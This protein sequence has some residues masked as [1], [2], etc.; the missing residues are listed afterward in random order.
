MID[1][2]RLERGDFLFRQPDQPIDGRADHG[3]FPRRNIVRHSKI[4][5]RAPALVGFDRRSPDKCFGEV[6]SQSRR[7]RDLEDDRSVSPAV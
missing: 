7:S 4:E 3:H 5:F 2:E 6:F 1:K